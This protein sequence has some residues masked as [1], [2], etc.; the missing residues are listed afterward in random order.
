M[1]T[2]TVS[3]ANQ[4]FEVPIKLPSGTY[5]SRRHRGWSHEQA[6]GSEPA[7]ERKNWMLGFM[8]KRTA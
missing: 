3:F 2:K 6:I 5:R 1:R 7:P 4:E 8:P